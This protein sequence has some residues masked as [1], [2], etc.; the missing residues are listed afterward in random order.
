VTTSESGIQ[1]IKRNEG[2][3]GFPYNDVGHWAWGYGHDQQPGE[4]IP[5]NISVAQADALLR[6]DIRT[7][8][9][10]GLNTYL[11]QHGITLTQNQF[12]A[13]VD[14]A[15][16]LG[17]VSALTMIA[18]GVDQVSM[19]IPRWNHIGTKEDAGLTA[20]RAAEVELWRK[21]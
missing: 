9:E 11:E 19:Q 10:P 14:F 13:W 3:A 18:H 16:N 4:A 2:Y 6:K 17:V 12:D 1:F 15:Y 8:Y 21:A 20:R 5:Q 7:R